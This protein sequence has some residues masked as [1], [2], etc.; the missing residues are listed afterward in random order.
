MTDQ[1]QRKRE[2]ILEAA[3]EICRW[4]I[5]DGVNQDDLWEYCSVCPVE[6]ALN[7]EP[8]KPK[9]EP[10][11]GRINYPILA[12]LCPYFQ[13]P[14][15]E[16]PINGTYWCQHCMMPIDESGEPAEETREWLRRG[17]GKKNVDSR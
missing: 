2:A 11:K 13:K 15:K 16:P 1:E 4:P 8:E 9:V 7:A 12:I 17:G 5:E 3:C 6:A 14:L 10:A